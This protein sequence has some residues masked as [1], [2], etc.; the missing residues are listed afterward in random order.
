MI[1]KVALIALSWI[2]A[3]H[4]APVEQSPAQLMLVTPHK[5]NLKNILEDFKPISKFNEAQVPLVQANDPVTEDGVVALNL[6]K[7]S[8]KNKD[9]E[10]EVPWWQHLWNSYFGSGEDTED[11]VTEQ[12]A[13]SPAPAESPEPAESPSPAAENPEVAEETPEKAIA[14]EKSEIYRY[15]NQ[16]YVF[17]GEPQFY[18]SFNEKGDPIEPVFCVKTL[19]PVPES[20]LARKNV[21]VCFLLKDQRNIENAVKFKFLISN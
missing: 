5:I 21:M 6:V 13:E 3:R 7:N 15:N 1:F 2:A 10:E 14:Q 11:A 16:N 4:C 19:I 17:K 12:G 18:A 20:V 9:E 8:F